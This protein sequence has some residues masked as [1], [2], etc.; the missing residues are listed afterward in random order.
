MTHQ[1]CH[2]YPPAFQVFQII[3]SLAV[4]VSPPLSLFY[5]FPT[6]IN[7]LPYSQSTISKSIDQIRHPHVENFQSCLPTQN[8]SHGLTDQNVDEL[9]IVHSS[10][11]QER[12]T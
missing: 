12:S 7:S 6:K 4:Q 9:I 10:A 5:S 1:F 8:A 2:T 11:H 3:T